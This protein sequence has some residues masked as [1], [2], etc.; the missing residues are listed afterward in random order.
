M[1]LG[2]LQFFQQYEMLLTSDNYVTRRQSLKVSAQP[3]QVALLRQRGSQ[4]CCQLLQLCACLGAS[5][6]MERMSTAGASL[7]PMSSHAAVKRAAAATD[8]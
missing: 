5:P 6:A 8:C 7:E 4:L 3:S 1:A 2:A